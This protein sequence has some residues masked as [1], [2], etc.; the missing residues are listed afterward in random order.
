[1]QP[2]RKTQG[3]IVSN[4]L[5]CLHGVDHDQDVP[6]QGAGGFLG[7]QQDLDCA[8]M[9]KSALPGR[10]KRMSPELLPCE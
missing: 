1:V 10:I 3:T 2:N 6:K 4:Q 5:A 8:H 9:I 7:H